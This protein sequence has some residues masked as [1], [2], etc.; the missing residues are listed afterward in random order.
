MS[1]VTDAASEASRASP[2][3]DAPT[4]SSRFVRRPALASGAIALVAGG[5]AMW[6][7]ADAGGQRGVLA[8]AFLAVVAL[9][10][11]GRLWRRGRPV[12][13]LLALAG[14]IG[15]VVALQ[16]AATRP[17]LVVERFELVPAVAGLAVLAGGLVPAR[18]GW[19]RT[20]VDA[21]AGLLFVAVLV[22]GVVRGAA[23]EVLVAAGALCVLAW[24]AGENAVSLGSQLGTEARTLRGELAHVGASAAVAAVAVGGVLAVARLGVQGLSFGALGALLVAVVVLTLV[25]HR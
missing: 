20:L 17:T 7:V 12:G 6:L 5:L 22:S 1:G 18:A 24:D 8:A 16:L 21:G 11:G 23:P 2:R 9:A 19:E 15:V 14:G 3:E 25:Y 10:G 4:G 13:G